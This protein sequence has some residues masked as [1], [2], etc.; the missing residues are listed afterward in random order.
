MSIPIGILDQSPRFAGESAEDAFRHTIEL[1][2]IAEELGYRRFWVSEHHDSANVSGSSPEVL[3]SYLLAKTKKITIGSGGVM[4]QHYSPYKVAENFNVLSTLAPGRVE[5]GI[6]RAPGGLPRSTRALQGDHQTSPLSL[7]DK[8]I[9]TRNYIYNRIADDHALAG[10]HVSP[11]PAQPADL[12]VLGASSNS[13]EVAAKLGLPYVF[14]QFI[15]GD[16]EVALTAVRNYREQFIPSIEYP[17]P[18]VILA[19]SVIVAETE[20]EAA[21]LAGENLSVKIHLESGK[22][23]TVATIEQAEEFGRQSAEK[24]RI[25]VKEAKVVKGSPSSVY[26]QLSDIRQRYGIEELVVHTVIQNFHKRVRSFELL[27]QAFVQAEV[28]ASLEV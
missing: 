2:Q 22:V 27:Q 21:Q 24:Y 23:L 20:E 14:S 8:I 26:Q 15:N 7:T 1:A 19:L 28:E 3:I 11:N 10:I 16:E 5:L 12:F 4:L 9:E 6:G 25:E 17:K 18:H 13:A